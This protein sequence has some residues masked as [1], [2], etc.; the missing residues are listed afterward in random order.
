MEGSH[1][2]LSSS[3]A[4][5]A[6]ARINSARRQGHR[7]RPRRRQRAPGCDASG[8]R[9]DASTVGNQPMT[10]MTD[11][12]SSDHSRLTRTR[13]LVVTCPGATGHH[14]QIWICTAEDDQAERNEPQQTT[15]AISTTTTSEDPRGNGHA[16]RSRANGPL[17]QPHDRHAVARFERG[18]R[19]K[20]N[21]LVWHF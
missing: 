10:S 4:V 7:Q 17:R 12:S 6:N 15:S 13:A 5:R 11:C 8:W 2:T 19:R 3:P 1:Q 21:R 9:R 18:E 14:R 16:Q 20:G